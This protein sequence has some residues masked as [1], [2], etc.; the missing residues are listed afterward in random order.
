[1]RKIVSREID[2]GNGVC[3]GTMCVQVPKELR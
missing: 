3:V 2:T 1:M